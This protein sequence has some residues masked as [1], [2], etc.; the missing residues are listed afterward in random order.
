MVSWYD[1]NRIQLG[2]ITNNLPALLEVQLTQQYRMIST[3]LYYNCAVDSTM[4]MVLNSLAAQKKKGTYHTTKQLMHF[5][6]YR[7]MHP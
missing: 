2:L 6:N 5:L 1:R 4:L 7:E 3:F